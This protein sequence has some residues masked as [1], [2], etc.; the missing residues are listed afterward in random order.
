VEAVQYQV[1]VAHR[2]EKPVPDDW[3][4]DSETWF[5]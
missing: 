2:E 1:T 4:L 5:I 3:F